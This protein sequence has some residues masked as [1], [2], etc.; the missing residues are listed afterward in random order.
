VNAGKTGDGEGSKNVGGERKNR[1]FG[2][3]HGVMGKKNASGEGN[4][5]PSKEG[6][7][8]KGTFYGMRTEKGRSKC[9]TRWKRCCRKRR[10]KRRWGGG[11]IQALGKRREE[12]AKTQTVCRAREAGRRVEKQDSESR[13]IH[14]MEGN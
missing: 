1:T 8:D 5:W 3:V 4:G 2:E 10:S 14:G 9:S 12:S 6:K 7:R 13:K 11:T